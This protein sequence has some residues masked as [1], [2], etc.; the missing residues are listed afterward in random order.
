[1]LGSVSI[2]RSIKVMEDKCYDNNIKFEK[3]PNVVNEST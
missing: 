2:K 3:H 1:M